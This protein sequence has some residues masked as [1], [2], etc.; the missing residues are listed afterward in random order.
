LSI[1]ESLRIVASLRRFIALLIFVACASNHE[2]VEADEKAPP[3]SAVEVA[4][5]P[6][7]ARPAPPVTARPVEA[8]LGL[9]AVLPAGVGW[10]CV[11]ERCGRTCVYPRPS[12]APGPDGRVVVHSRRPPCVDRDTAFCAAFVVTGQAPTVQCWATREACEEYRGSSS[13]ATACEER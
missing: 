10:K 6:E 3:V 5:T 11:H 9:D 7:V 13:G 2:G 1:R 12:H 8:P 4:P